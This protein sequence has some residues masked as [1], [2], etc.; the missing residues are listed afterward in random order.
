MFGS[1]SWNDGS[2]AFQ[3]FFRA[4]ETTVCLYVCNTDNNH[5]NNNNNNSNTNHSSNNNNSNNNNK[6]NN[7]N[8]I[9]IYTYIHTIDRFKQRFAASAEFF[10]NIASQL[11]HPGHL[12]GDT[13]R[14]ISPL[15]WWESGELPLKREEHVEL[16]GF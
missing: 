13:I 12:P 1:A 8:D 3:C 15:K 9:Y 16:M 11:G 7:N 4:V 10:S 5:N 14:H 2:P 6:N